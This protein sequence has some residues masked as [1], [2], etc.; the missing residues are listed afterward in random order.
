M[1]KNEI[2]DIVDTTLF[3]GRTLD[4]KLRWK[5][6]IT[7]LAIRLSSAAYAVKRIRRLTDENTA[8][9]I[10][11]SFLHSLITHKILLWGHA[12]DVNTV[13]ILEKQAVRAIYDLRPM[14]SLR[15]K[16]KEIISQL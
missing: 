12:A 16:F 4:A 5:H 1:V 3:L 11:F 7:R 9:L 13:F 10:Y 14:A 6:H 8:G 15:E 2:L